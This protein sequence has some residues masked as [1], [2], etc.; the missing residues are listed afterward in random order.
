MTKKNLILF[1]VF[2]FFMIS[3]LQAGIY[4]SPEFGWSW[5]KFRV[6]ATAPEQLKYCLELEGKQKYSE[7]ISSYTALIKVFSTGPEVTEAY[8]RI[9]EL[10]ILDGK[11]NTAHRHYNKLLES[12]IKVTTE[13]FKN[14]IERKRN[15][16]LNSRKKREE[17]DQLMFQ[18]LLKDLDVE[19][20]EN[21]IKLDIPRILRSLYEI[22]DA[23][24]SGSRYRLFGSI[25][26][27]KQKSK[28]EVLFINLL[29]RAPNVDYAATMRYKVALYRY[30][31]RDYVEAIQE[32]KR[33]TYEYSLSDEAKLSSY[34]IGM[35]HFH[36]YK[37]PGHNEINLTSAEANLTDYINATPS[38]E[39]AE[40]ARNTI[41]L[42]SEHKAETMIIKIKFFIR[43]KQWRAAG[44]YIKEVQKVFPKS[45]AA[46]EAVNIQAKNEKIIF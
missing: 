19:R 38:G 45:D 42:M 23:Y 34:Y 11:V 6:K 39:K 8:H 41:Q 3:S 35:S 15:R 10:L 44:I 24:L 21:A 46:K 29:K 17:N 20:D 32:F 16:N 33:L 14:P 13:K 22:G 9:G 25:P 12:Q 27:W 7:A 30:N 40:D 1:L 43:R 4:Y 37:G 36:F 5:G 18:I 2:Y 26:L 28:G 31:K